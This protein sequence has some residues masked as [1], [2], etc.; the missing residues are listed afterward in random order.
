M[1]LWHDVEIDEE[2]PRRY[3]AVSRCLGADEL[4]RVIAVEVELGLE[5]VAA[6]QFT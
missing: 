4:G 3:R 1:H 6:L 2:R 5:L